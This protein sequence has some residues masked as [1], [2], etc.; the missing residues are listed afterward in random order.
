MKHIIPVVLAVIIMAFL[1]VGCTKEGDDAFATGRFQVVEDHTGVTTRETI[2]VD[3]ETN[4]LYIWVREGYAG[5][6]TPLLD[7]DGNVQFWNEKN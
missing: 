1:L 4:V 2:L 3:T 7:G 5:G 6:L